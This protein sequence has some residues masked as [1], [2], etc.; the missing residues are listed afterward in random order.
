MSLQTSI[1][2]PTKIFAS[3]ISVIKDC[4][5][6]KEGNTTNLTSLKWKTFQNCPSFLDAASVTCNRDAT[7]IK[8]VSGEFIRRVDAAC[9]RTAAN[10]NRTTMPKV[11]SKSVVCEL[12]GLLPSPLLS[13]VSSPV[14]ED[15]PR[16]PQTNTVFQ[17]FDI[18]YEGIWKPIF[19]DNAVCKC[20]KIIRENCVRL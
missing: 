3:Q 2:G 6:F 8:Q 15:H 16:L 10:S 12:R 13:G 7:S 1:N 9:I 20:N 17:N 11:L 19:I 18:I 5:L 4:L 14:E